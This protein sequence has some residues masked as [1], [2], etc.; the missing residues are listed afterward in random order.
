MFTANR[1]L[2]Y[3]LQFV[4]G[5]LVARF[6]GPQMFGIWGF[7]LL[8]QQYLSYT[9]LG[10]QYAVNV[11]LA[12]ESTTAP[13]KRAELIGSALIFTALI[14]GGLVLLGFWIQTGGIPLFEKYFFTRYVLAI[15]VICGFNHLQQ[16]FAN[17]Y[18]VYGKLARI[19]VSELLSAVFPLMTVLLFKGEILIQAL[20]SALVL[21]GIISLT[22]Y[23]VKVPFKI[24]FKFNL[25][26][27]RQLLA[28]GIPLLVNN[29]SYYLIT[30][31][32][33]TIISAFYS[34]QTMGYYSLANTISAATLLGLNAV[35]WVFFP[36]ILSR[37]HAGISDEMAEGVVKKVNEL[38]ATAAFLA[39]FGMILGLPVIF[40]FLPQ[41]QPVAGALSVLLL[42]QALLSVSFGYNCVAIARKKQLKVAGISMIAAIVVAGLS[43]LVA[44]FKMSFTW[45]AVA[46]LVG[47]S[48][49]TLWLTRLG[50]RM[51]ERDR[52][53]I[54][55]MKSVLPWGSL[56]AILIFLAGIPVGY[57]TPAGLIGAAIF[58]LTNRQKVGL[59]WNF[60][61][62]IVIG[63]PWGNASSK[64]RTM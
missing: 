21:S 54:G 57:P 55:Y 28:M 60:I 32:G 6:L 34:V 26:Y 33:R 50:E 47:A 17:I 23:I 27:W 9:S 48:V 29:V 58:I 42:S 45:I 43:L 40:L 46:V 22:I 19:A 31:S 52:V 25:Y 30:V 61:R 20:L 18:R 41:Y 7:L 24:A 2:S 38:Y 15:S 35:S 5:I 36:G 14:S 62:R 49:Y 11:E 37:T 12:T 44:L 53:G 8:V 63:Q 56:A 1:Y 59:V 51:L 10:L 16:L 64:M 39:V 4:R 13:K 3:G